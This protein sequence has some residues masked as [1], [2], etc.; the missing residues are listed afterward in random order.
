M[1]IKMLKSWYET[2]HTPIAKYA[3]AETHLFTNDYKQADAVLYEI[4]SMFDF[5]E[6][7]QAEYDNYMSFY[8]LKKDVQ[9]AERDWSE[10]K[11]DEI[12]Q[13]KSI[14]ELKTGRSSTMAK[15]VL[16]FFYNICYEDDVII[17]E[18]EV[19]PK[20]ITTSDEVVITLEDIITED[21]DNIDDIVKIEVY[22]MTGRLLY[23]IKD[24]K[25][26]DFVGLRSGIYVAKVYTKDKR[27]ISNKFIKK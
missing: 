18:P 20:S 21:I 19:N 6:R 7:E 4:P 27:V 12:Y 22:D 2:V 15:G 25:E 13:L 9:L 16:C 1:D 11:E 17:E 14:A 23:L 3:L 8:N 5:G 24:N 10:L 26:V